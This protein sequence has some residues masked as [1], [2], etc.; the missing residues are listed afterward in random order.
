MRSAHKIVRGFELILIACIVLGS[1]ASAFPLKESERVGMEFRAGYSHQ[2]LEDIGS[3]PAYG[4]RIIF[5]TPF[6]VTGYVGGEVHTSEGEPLRVPVLPTWSLTSAKSTIYL[7]P[8]HIGATYAIAWERANAYAGGGFSWVTLHERTEATYV[9]GDY[10]L[11]EWTNA[12]G[13]G[14]GI[15]LSV[16]TRYLVNPDFSLFAEVEGLA[17][18]IDYVR[19]EKVRTRSLA[20]FVGVR[21]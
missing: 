17:S 20:L 16:G 18:W 15:H 21:F 5:V 6:G 13:S 4:A 11:T 10:I 3:G 1:A 7:M 14:P 2:M 19:P 8:A 12:G 9:S